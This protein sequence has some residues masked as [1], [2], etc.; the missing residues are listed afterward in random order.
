MEVLITGSVLLMAARKL[1]L[2]LATATRQYPSTATAIVI[3]L[4]ASYAEVAQSAIPTPRVLD[5]R[6]THWRGA[7][8]SLI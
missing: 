7:P 2:A 3:A 8:G 5:K 4:I 6:S 1:V